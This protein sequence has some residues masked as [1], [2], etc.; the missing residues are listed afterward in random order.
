M[1]S[2]EPVKEKCRKVPPVENDDGDDADED[3]EEEE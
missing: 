3:E 2:R 1:P